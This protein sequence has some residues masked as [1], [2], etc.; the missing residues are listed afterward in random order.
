[1]SEQAAF[2]MVMTLIGF[3]VG[4]LVGRLFERY[5]WIQLIKLGVIAKPKPPVQDSEVIEESD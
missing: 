4:Y 2:I 1:M 3:V 5:S